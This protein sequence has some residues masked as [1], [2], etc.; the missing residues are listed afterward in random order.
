MSNRKC[1]KWINF[2]HRPCMKKKKKKKHQSATYY[3]L[4]NL[5]TPNSILIH[6]TLSIRHSQTSLRS[7]SHTFGCFCY[8][9]KLSLL[10]NLGVSIWR[11]RRCQRWR[12]DV[13]RWGARPFCLMSPATLLFLRLEQSPRSWE[14]LQPFQVL[15]MFSILE[16]F[17][18]SL[19]LFLFLCLAFSRSPEA[20]R[21]V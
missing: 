13:L 4:P 20:S 2:C 6:S 12:T 9:I 3:K 11:S 16:F 7:A 15:V 14:P 10:Y 17:S 18:E 1:L 5:A 21:F 19:I 8:L